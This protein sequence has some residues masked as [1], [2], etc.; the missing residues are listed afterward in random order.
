[1]SKD[2]RLESIE[3][4][5]TVG[6]LELLCDELQR[7]SENGELTENNLEAL[8]GIAHLVYGA[9]DK[10]AA[11]MNEADFDAVSK[12]SLKY[13]SSKVKNAILRSSDHKWSN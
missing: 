13:D 2:L 7:K 8:V 1:M 10:H 3:L 9:A 11:N 6:G 4:A 12:G 5:S